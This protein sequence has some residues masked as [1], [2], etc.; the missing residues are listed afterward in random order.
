MALNLD[1][2]LVE[3]VGGPHPRAPSKQF[4]YGIDHG[5]HEI[6]ERVAAGKMADQH[7]APARLAYA[8]H[9]VHHPARL[10]NDG[11]NVERGD[12]VEAV[13]GE[14]QLLRIAF[15]QFDVPCAVSLSLGDRMRE[16]IVGWVNA[17]DSHVRWISAQ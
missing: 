17:D 7:D 14:F 8:Y 11:H 13:V 9:L 16:H 5:P 2:L 1:R 3:D 10:G 15:T 12:P 4:G 6:E